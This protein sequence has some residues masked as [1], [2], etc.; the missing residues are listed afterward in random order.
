MELLSDV[1]NVIDV[2]DGLFEL[3]KLEITEKNKLVFLDHLNDFND[4]SNLTILIC[5]KLELKKL[6]K[7]KYNTKYIAKNITTK[8]TFDCENNEF[9]A[10]TAF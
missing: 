7:P 10:S 3:E 6:P 2:N 8:S 1:D 5:V 4:F 9:K